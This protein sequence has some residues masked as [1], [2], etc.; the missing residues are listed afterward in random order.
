MDENTVSL[1]FN[2]VYMMIIM[3]IIVIIWLILLDF[4]EQTSM[5]G[6]FQSLLFY[7]LCCETKSFIKRG[8]MSQRLS[9]NPAVTQ[10]G[11]ETSQDQWDHTRHPVQHYT[12]LFILQNVSVW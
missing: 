9:L 8:Q 11:S 10:S 2:Q 7:V 6:P 4:T 5:C 1:K 3:I 12:E